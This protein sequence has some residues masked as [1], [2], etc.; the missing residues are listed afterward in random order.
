MKARQEWRGAKLA[1]KDVCWMFGLSIRKD[2]G[3][4]ML[5]QSREPNHRVETGCVQGGLSRHLTAQCRETTTDLKNRLRRAH[6][7]Y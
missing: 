6:R 3:W 1:A 7:L 2:R 4:R 5:E